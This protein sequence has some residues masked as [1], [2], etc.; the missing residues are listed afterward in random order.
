MPRGRPKGSKNRPKDVSQ[1]LFTEDKIN[2]QKTT[3]NT[4][5][6]IEE[7][8]D[9]TDANIKTLV[10]EENKKLPQKTPNILGYCDKCHKPV[11]SSFI[12]ANLSHLTGKAIWHRDCNLER[13]NLCSD[14][15]AALNS[16]IDAWILKDNPQYKKF[17]L[18]NS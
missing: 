7:T 5:K 10:E 6:I 9:L 18:E 4:Q 1:N 11:Y 15:G 3:I 13:L 16:I 8:K 2:T 12:T 17:S 14:C